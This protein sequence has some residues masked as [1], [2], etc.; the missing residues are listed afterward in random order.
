[1]PLVEWKDEYR[2]GIASVDH[3]HE[4]LI[5]LLNDLH[6]EVQGAAEI[7]SVLAFFG[8]VHARIS[9]HFALE[10]RIMRKQRY[11]QYLDHKSDHERLL[12]G[13]RDIA[14]DYEA[15]L[16][17][18]FK[19]VLSAHLGEWFTQHFKTRDARMHKILG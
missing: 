8:E 9:A 11:D 10:E 15:G 12:D 1:M 6:A 5:R 19:E 17:G 2:T 7:D 18:D 14:D 16:Y 13:I 4:A 3:E